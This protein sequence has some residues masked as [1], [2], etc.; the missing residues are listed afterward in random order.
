MN[1]KPKGP[2]TLSKGAVSEL[3]NKLA[4]DLQHA[5]ERASSPTSIRQAIIKSAMQQLPG[6]NLN[7]ADKIR[8]IQAF[9]ASHLEELGIA[10]VSAD[11]IKRDL[12]AVATEHSSKSKARKAQQG[13]AVPVR[14]KD[15]NGERRKGQDGGREF[16]SANA[17]ASEQADT[18]LAN[19]DNLFGEAR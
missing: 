9:F 17:S 5:A 19:Q 11:T 13:T 12:N 8:I 1:T 3:G 18:R 6:L 15:A 10:A 2:A 14:S 16:G 7:P 4:A